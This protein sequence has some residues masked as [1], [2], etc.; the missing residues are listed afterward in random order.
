[1]APRK[2]V[3]IPGKDRKPRERKVDEWPPKGTLRTD[4]DGNVV[5]EPFEPTRLDPLIEPAAAAVPD[6]QPDPPAPAADPAPSIIRPSAIEIIRPGD[7]VKPSAAISFN[8]LGFMTFYDLM[9]YGMF[10]L[11]AHMYPLAQAL[12]DD[13][14]KKLLVIIG[15]GSGKAVHPDT[16]VLTKRGWIRM[17]DITTDDMVMIPD[18]KTWV[19]VR[20]VFKQPLSKLY[21]MEFAD[22]RV[23]RANGDHVWKAY[24]KKFTLGNVGLKW[25]LR[26]T[27][28][29]YRYKHA[30]R[31]EQ[32]R[33]YIPL[34]EPIFG[35]RIDVLLDPYT[36]GCL[37]GD[38]CIHDDGSCVL[39]SADD[40][41]VDKIRSAGITVNKHKSKFSYGVVGIA[42]IMCALGL[43]GSRSWDKHIPDIYL[44]ASIE[45]RYELI[46]GLMDTD[47]YVDTQ[48]TVSFCSVSKQ[49]AS[50]V[51]YLIRSVGGIADTVKKIKSFTSHGAKKIGRSAYQVNIRH[52]QSELL[53]NL[54]RKKARAGETQY[55][56]D[57]KLEI[58][59]IEQEDVYDESVCININ[60]PDG[61]FLLEDFIVTHNS[62]CI[63]VSF[64]AF[65]LGCRP[66]YTV[67]GISAGESLMTGFQSAVMNWIEFSPA[68]KL[69]FPNVRPNKD[70]GWSTE[71][72]MFVTGHRSGDP[73]ASYIGMGLSSKRLTGVH[74]RIILGDDLHDKDNS[75]SE[76]SCLKVRETFYK[77]IM[78]RADPQGA[79]Y[80]MVGRRW[81][82]QD[83]YGH[84][85]QTGEWV[86]MNLPA[87]RPKKELI[88]E[89]DAHKLYWDV[90]VPH[91]LK[92][93]FND[94]DDTND[95]NDSTPSAA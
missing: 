33:W 19:A 60:H 53:F 77:Q 35:K 94:T 86:V 52:P 18:G 82:E 51:A 87:M 20:G 26:T 54:D 44:N 13:R 84:L 48:H 49:L 11:P 64:V 32:P 85:A 29:I 27:E 90:S 14:I 63:S 67:V 43:N 30:G 17:G 93:C 5:K 12:T 75:A 55:S 2:Q 78:G 62:Y 65:L 8:A 58:A 21:R 22:G 89:G 57:L 7:D 9:N 37:L 10:S 80:M 91:G 46:R 68:W 28:E 42:P 41:I 24:N 81:H 6:P 38:G 40:Q 23:V 25:R 36:L 70:L 95:T 72:G 74:G 79:R 83:I 50:D 66:D 47:G 39:T 56:E 92:C 71:A 34:T 69:M 76:E 61:L 15:P 31:K 3:L 88:K 4:A 1:M 73:D 16:K 59:S 45:Q